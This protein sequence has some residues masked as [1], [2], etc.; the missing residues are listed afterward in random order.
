MQ[1]VD[2]NDSAVNSKI[3]TAII[4]VC[5]IVVMAVVYIFCFVSGVDLTGFDT[6]IILYLIVGALGAL[7][8]NNLKFGQ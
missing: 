5:L 4:F 2:N 1:L 6:K 3:V 8:V 7:G